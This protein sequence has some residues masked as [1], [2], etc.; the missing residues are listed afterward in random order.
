MQD[1]TDEQLL[2]ELNTLVEPSPQR[3]WRDVPDFEGLY[4]ISSDGHL[5]S[6]PR[7]VPTGQRKRK[8]RMRLMKQTKRVLD[9]KVVSISSNLSDSATGAH[10]FMTYAAMMLE[11]FV[12]PRPS[13]DHIA[14][15]VNGLQ[16]DLRLDNLEWSTQRIVAFKF[17]HGAHAVQAHQPQENHLLKLKKQAAERLFLR[18]EIAAR[19][20]ASIVLSPQD[21]KDLFALPAIQDNAAAQARELRINITPEG[22]IRMAAETPQSI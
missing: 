7:E 13:P 16:E 1:I 19:T 11:A 20:E 15:T 21:C 12:G 17:V 14:H 10:K 6:L 9:G 5:V 2:R 22:Y 3:R 18:I 4:A 8:L